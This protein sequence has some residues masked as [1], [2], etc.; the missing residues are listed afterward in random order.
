MTS[1]SQQPTSKPEGFLRRTKFVLR[2]LAA[3]VFAFSIT[4][5]SR[6][7]PLIAGVSLIGLIASIVWVMAGAFKRSPVGID[8]KQKTKVGKIL[9]AFLAGPLA[10]LLVMAIG[11]A[12]S[13]SVK[14][15]SAAE[16]AQQGRDNAAQ[17]HA[18]AQQAENASNCSAIEKNISRA[19]ARSRALQAKVS[20][21]VDAESD[22]NF[23]FWPA[24]YAITNSGASERARVQDMLF[25]YFPET[26]QGLMKR[27]ARLSEKKF[28]ALDASSWLKDPALGS[29]LFV[30]FETN[31][32][33]GSTVKP[34]SNIDTT[35]F[36]GNQNYGTGSYPASFSRYISTQHTTCDVK[37]FRT[38][39]EPLFDSVNYDAVDGEVAS[40]SIEIYGCTVYGKGVSDL[41]N[42]KCAAS[43]FVAKDLGGGSG[44]TTDRNPFTDPYSSDSL[45]GLAKFSWCWDQGLILNP[46]GTAC[47]VDQNQHIDG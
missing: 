43:Q 46:D 30:A 9:L 11:F 13:L 10:S 21:P 4:F 28:L 25:K 8:G 24:T 5:T 45:N 32:L 38:E 31:L 39:L 20:A 1:N 12:G 47:M 23:W 16:L 44:L 17:A 35:S 19:S 37:K 41:G 33:K 14:P 40:L 2:F 7:A 29:D 27:M 15:Y 3:L 22:T 34:R 26:Q 42:G 36:F 18:D 6:W